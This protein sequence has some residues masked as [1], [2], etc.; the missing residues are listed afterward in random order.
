MIVIILLLLSSIAII[1]ILLWRLQVV[2]QENTKVKSTEP[3]NKVSI[4]H[5]APKHTI[6]LPPKPPKAPLKVTRH[7]K[8]ESLP[9]LVSRNKYVIG[10]KTSDR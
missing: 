8:S 7:A 6:K 4:N 9:E 2:K 10:A 5:E 1:F 3:V